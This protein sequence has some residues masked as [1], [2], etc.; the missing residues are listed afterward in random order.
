[1]SISMIVQKTVQFHSHGRKFCVEMGIPDPRT[2]TFTSMSENNGTHALLAPRPKRTITASSKLVDPQ[3]TAEPIRSHK[4]AIELKWAAELANKQLG[5]GDTASGP[6]D[7]GTSRNRASLSTLPPTVFSPLELQSTT[8]N[9]DGNTA[10]NS[11]DGSDSTDGAIE[12]RK[13]SSPSFSW[14]IVDLQ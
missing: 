1:M 7:S 5:V 8:E 13:Q 3:N 14:L 4:H 2:R 10:G 12:H 6:L 11:E 9:V